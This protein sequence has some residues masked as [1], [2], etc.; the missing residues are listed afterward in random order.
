MDRT[1][2]DGILMGDL[3][4]DLNTAKNRKRKD[5]VLITRSLCH[6]MT[7]L[8]LFRNEETEEVLWTWISR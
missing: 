8:I 7:S 4:V 1:E 3:N 2:L 6:L 5:N